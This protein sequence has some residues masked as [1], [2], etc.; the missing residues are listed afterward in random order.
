MSLDRRTALVC[1]ASKGIGRATAQALAAAGAKV[2]LLARSTDLLEALREEI[3]ASGGRADVVVADLDDREGLAGMARGLV[4]AH[5]PVHILVNNS[6]GPPGGPLLAA[7]PDALLVAF[8]RHV[9]AAHLLVQAFLPGM[10]EAGYGRV[11][12]VIS[13]SVREPIP[14]LG[15]SNTIR[16]AMASWAKSLSRELPP[17][18]TINNVL[19]GFT[20]TERLASLGEKRAAREG[21]SPE[22]VHRAWLAQVPERRLAQP[23]ETAAAIAFLSS[24][25]AAY[26]RGVSLPVDGGRLRSI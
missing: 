3:R 21:T 4:A 26:I 5:G 8:G 12:N 18:V 13:T 20:D 10:T 6:A 24:P 25:A 16:G 22:D 19:P 1:G 9:L 23:Q 2:L 14:N 15:V 11:I 7:T 17:G